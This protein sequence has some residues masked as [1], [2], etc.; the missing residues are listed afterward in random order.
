MKMRLNP[1]SIPI[2]SKKMSN[3]EGCER[4]CIDTWNSPI[5]P[6]IKEEPVIVKEEP[7]SPS[8]KSKSKSKVKVKVLQHLDMQG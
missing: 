3:D 7:L 8:S 5:G 4:D 1:S 2:L 6:R